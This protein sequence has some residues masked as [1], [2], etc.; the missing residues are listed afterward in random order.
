MLVTSYPGAG[1]DEVLRTLRGIQSAVQDAGKA[2]GPAH[3]RLTACPEWA[4]DSFR[5]LEHRVSTADIDRL[6]LTR[7]YCR[8]VTSKVPM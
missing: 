7:G 2:H 6:V 1:R 5:M 4:T 8:L 3:S